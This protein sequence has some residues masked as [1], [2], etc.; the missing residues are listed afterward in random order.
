MPAPVCPTRISRESVVRWHQRWYKKKDRWTPISNKTSPFFLATI[1]TMGC[2][3][4]KYEKAKTLVINNSGLFVFYI[5]QLYAMCP[6]T[7]L[8]LHAFVRQLARGQSDHPAVAFNLPC[9]DNRSTLPWRFNVPCRDATLS[10]HLVL[11][12]VGYFTTGSS[13]DDKWKTVES[14]PRIFFLSFLVDGRVG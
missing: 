7:F 3:C 12:L 9:R 14:F 5:Q 8:L 11:L 6:S 13:E 4:W 2:Y 1:Y 10:W